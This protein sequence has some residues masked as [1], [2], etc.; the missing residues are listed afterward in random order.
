MISIFVEEHLFKSDICRLLSQLVVLIKNYNI[1]RLD[2]RFIEIKWPVR[3]VKNQAIVLC[4]FSLE[5]EIV[6]VCWFMVYKA[7]V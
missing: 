3:R 5:A 4:Y 2:E 7:G 6:E 1:L